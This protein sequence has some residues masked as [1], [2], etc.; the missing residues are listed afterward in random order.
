MSQSVNVVNILR[1]EEPDPQS[2]PAKGGVNLPF[3]SV[4]RGQAQRRLKE[5]WQW[6]GLQD[7]VSIRS[8]E[9]GGATEVVWALYHLYRGEAWPL[10][11][12]LKRKEHI[13]A[14]GPVWTVR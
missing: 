2:G 12:V 1:E 8:G 10:E 11:E 14:A 13:E 5:T 4:Y 9:T 6:F 7:P 3:D